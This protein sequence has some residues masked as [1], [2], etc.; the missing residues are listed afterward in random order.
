MRACPTSSPEGGL[1]ARSEV[2]PRSARSRMPQRS[3]R[4]VGAE[5]AKAMRCATCSTP[6]R[7]LVVC[8]FRWRWRR[9]ASIPPA[10]N[11][12][13]T[14]AT[15][16]R[17]TSKASAIL[18]SGQALPDKVRSGPCLESWM[19]PDSISP[20]SAFKRMRARVNSRAGARPPLSMARSF[21]RSPADKRTGLFL[22]L[23]TVETPHVCLPPRIQYG[24]H[25]AQ[26]NR[27]KVLMQID[28]VE[29]PESYRLHSSPH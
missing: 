20:S 25:E 21:W 18:V 27:K 22:F 3:P 16:E 15:V 10:T 7:F 2:I 5:Q 19:A 29:T 13:R 1:L 11:L 14:R 8:L 23:G 17:L 9:A 26:N 24:E 12:S 6:S 4:L 28:H